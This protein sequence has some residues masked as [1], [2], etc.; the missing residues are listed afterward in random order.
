MMTSDR[1]WI[2]ETFEQDEIPQERLTGA[3]LDCPIWAKHQPRSERPLTK[4][5]TNATRETRSE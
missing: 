5:R 4:R 2:L 3:T 1:K